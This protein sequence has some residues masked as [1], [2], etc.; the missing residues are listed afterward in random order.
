[1][2][3]RCFSER[4][5][6]K[7]VDEALQIESMNDNLK[8]SLWSCLYNFLD[9][10]IWD[11]KFMKDLYIY[12]WKQPI[13]RIPYAPY[14]KIKLLRKVY[15]ENDWNDIY[16][17]IEFFCFYYI[18]NSHDNIN[19]IFQEEINEILERENSGYRLIEG[20][21][22]PITDKIEIDSLKENFEKSPLENIKIHF[23]K[24]LFHLSDRNNPDFRNSIKESISAVECIC[25]N[26]TGERTLDR[27]LPKLENNGI[28]IPDI[29]KKGM[30]K[31]YYWT[32]GEDGIRHALMDDTENAGFDEAK[33]ML[34]VCSAF[35]NY[36]IS[37]K[38]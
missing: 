30:E 17:F 15:F 2:K 38:A 29:L 5:K 28:N 10:I 27:A 1:M 8:N 23:D 25:R 9:S 3:F 32:N 18:N 4:N 33:Y 16:D 7:K 24:A 11:E 19:E 6:F 22:T 31:I 26:I 20:C 14:D 12:L 35:V 13:D 37:K 34:I 36:I 21:I